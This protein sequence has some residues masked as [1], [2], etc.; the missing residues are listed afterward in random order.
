M[1][2]DRHEGFNLIQKDFD[3]VRSTPDLN[4]VVELRN[5]TVHIVSTPE[6][7]ARAKASTKPVASS[8]PELYIIGKRV[9]RR[10]VVNQAVLGQDLLRLL[11]DEDPRIAVPDTAPGK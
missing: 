6:E 9:G 8:R 1:D 5:V 2:Q 7:L 3:S 4:E 11:G 10:I